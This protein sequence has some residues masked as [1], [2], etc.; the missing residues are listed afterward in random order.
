MPDF[1]ISSPYAIWL[2]L[3]LICIILELVTGGF[4]MLFIGGS[5]LLTGLV[6]YLGLLHTI[7]LR[8]GFFAVVT[9]VSLFML[10]RLPVVQNKMSGTAVKNPVGDTA[11]VVTEISAST[12]GQ[13]EH[14]GAPWTAVSE[15]GETIPSGARVRIL[16]QDGLKFYVTKI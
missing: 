15:N 9:L 2:A 6:T 13:I 5:A 1:L 12:P 3:G 7:E 4:W 16:R 8:L 10:R 14:Q 11:H